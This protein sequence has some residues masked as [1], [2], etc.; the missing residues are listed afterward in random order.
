[1]SEKRVGE[2][3]KKHYWELPL[4]VIRGYLEEPGPRFVDPYAA[5]ERK[6]IQEVEWEAEQELARANHAKTIAKK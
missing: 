2:S 6:A 5:E 1:V 4:G 3:V